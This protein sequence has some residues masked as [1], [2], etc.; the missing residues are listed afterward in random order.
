MAKKTWNQKLNSGNETY[1]A[2]IDCKFAAKYGSRMLVASPLEY[3]AIMKQVPQGKLITADR[4]NGYLAKKH[5]ADWTCHLTAGIFIN[6]VANAS[7]ERKGEN[8]TPYWRTLKKGGEL[9]EKFPGGLDG[10]KIKLEMEGHKVI[11][12]GKRYFVEA[13]ESKLFDL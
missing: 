2:E 8:E 11:Q 3:D 13:F 1:I 12:K 6:I 5:G 4:I 9:N 10:H 7:A